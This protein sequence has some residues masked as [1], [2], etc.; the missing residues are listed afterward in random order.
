MHF[1]S[2]SLSHSANIHSHIMDCIFCKIIR[3]EIPCHRIVET[4]KTL[5]FPDLSPLSPGHILVIPKAHAARL[6]ELDS[7]SAAD[8]GRVLQKLGKVVAG[9]KGDGEYNILQNN[10][11]MA[12]QAVHHVHF[13]IIPKPNPTTGLVMEWDPIAMS[14]DALKAK[15]E[16]MK[17]A[18]DRIIA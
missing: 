2:P 14:S 7:D 6:H 11:E 16:E 5:V 3:G 17:A 8:I 18:Y 13:H 10:G 4:A 9:E 1:F 15:A 12:H